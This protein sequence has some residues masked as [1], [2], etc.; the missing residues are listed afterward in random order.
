MPTTGRTGRAAAAGIAIPVP[1]ACARVI[2][3]GADGAATVV[4]S[5]PRVALEQ[6]AARVALVEVR[7]PES[8]SGAL[9]VSDRQAEEKKP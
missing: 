9:Y 1:A 5:G 6:G 8:A 4:G 2:R 7:V 3:A